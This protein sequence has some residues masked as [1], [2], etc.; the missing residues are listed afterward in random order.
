M[1]EGQEGLLGG[2][3]G[4]GKSSGLLMAALQYVQYPSYSALLLRRSFKDLSLPGA[5]MDRAFDWL[6]DTDA[7]WDDLT[8]SW[9]FPS[10]ATL[11]FGYLEA[12]RDKFRYQ[13][14][15]YQFV[16]FDELSQFLESQYLY[17]FSRLRRLEGSPIP[18]RMRGASNPGDVGHCVPYGDV[19]TKD[20]GWQ[21]IKDIQI[22]ELVASMDDNEQLIYLPVEQK[23]EEEY[24]GEL[25]Y[26]KSTTATVICTPNHKIIRRTHTKTRSG[27]TWHK[28]TA[29]QIKDVSGTTNFIRATKNGW[30]GEIIKTFTPERVETRRTR[31]NQPETING[32]DYCELMGWFLSEGYVLDR[33]K[34]FGICQSK[35]QN[36]ILIRDLLLR[37][38]FKFRESSGGYHISSPTWWNYLHQFGKCRDKYIPQIIK[39]SSLEQ[40]KI[41]Y[42][43][44]MAGDGCGT[45]YYTTSKTLADDM[46]EIG[47]KLGYSPSI[48]SRSRISRRGLSYDIGFRLERDG[49]ME[50]K[51]IRMM[52]Y[53]G[54]VYC[55]GIPEYHRFFI[56]QDGQPWLSGNSWV[57]ERFIT[58]KGKDR[59]FIP[60]TYL[61]NP[62][63][64][65]K[66]YEQSLDKLDPIT[67]AQLKEG[68]WDVSFSS[69]LF[70]REWFEFVDYIP[71]GHQIRCWDLAATEQ[72]DYNDPDYTVGCLMVEKDGTFYIKDIVRARAT[73]GNVEKLVRHTAEH[74]GIKVRIIIEQEPG[75]SGKTVIEDYTKRILK[76][77]AAYGQRATG[78]KVT[79]AQPLS[80]AASHGN[81]KLSKELLT[82]MEL[83]PNG[84]TKSLAEVLL[85]EM[86]LFPLGKHD[87]CVDSVSASF[88]QLSG[89][90]G[91]PERFLTM[92]AKR[93]RY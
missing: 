60:A 45:H 59:F 6:S 10:G 74:D 31:L 2:S 68:N 92:I 44:I 33:D 7:K 15:N 40:L 50:K 3:A 90:V 46:Q 34:E 89:A 20:R 43:A 75:S 86:Q 61:D 63:L 56:R 53:E 57:K 69:G 18:I 93:R 19:L 73:P 30:M 84:T 77:F 27:R 12:E 55:L 38:G 37:I 28:P 24:K 39:N 17:L 23:T 58:Y 14:S 26:F 42:S 71:T 29:I 16:G 65:Q 4:P 25:C 52:H 81:V 80:A 47:L 49:W 36:R 32:D 76:G 13:G 78:D 87:D 1:R 62:Y 51:D 67:R 41:F 22:G 88:N 5:L 9:S 70:R 8:K 21:D 82:K 72:K 54:K 35:T 48:S 91:R 64:D 79:R 11:T 66:S 83:Q 85:S